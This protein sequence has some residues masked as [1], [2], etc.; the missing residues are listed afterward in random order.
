MT[1]DDAWA[2]DGTDMV[3]PTRAH[4]DSLRT[5]RRGDRYIGRGAKQYGLSKSLWANPHTG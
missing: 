5:W 2:S 3:V 4:L 1:F